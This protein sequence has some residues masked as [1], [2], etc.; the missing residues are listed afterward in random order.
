MLGI[1]PC[2]LKFYQELMKEAKTYNYYFPVK[3]ALTHEFRALPKKLQESCFS[4]RYFREIYDLKQADR[5][6][7]VRPSFV[8]PEQLENREQVVLTFDSDIVDVDVPARMAS[9]KKPRVAVFTKAYSFENSKFHHAMDYTQA[10]SIKSYG[11]YAII[12]FDNYHTSLIRYD[13]NHSTVAELM[14]KCSPMKSDLDNYRVLQSW[15][16]SSTL[17][18]DPLIAEATI[19]YALVTFKCSSKDGELRPIDLYSQSSK[20]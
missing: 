19:M 2:F 15:K 12:E 16:Q 9:K 7:D 20:Q 5:H 10:K 13:Y 11:G 17:Q 1:S 14:S 18:I 3:V 4:V 6:C 8:A